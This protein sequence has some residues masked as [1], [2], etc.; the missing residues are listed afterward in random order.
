MPHLTVIDKG[1]LVE[2]SLFKTKPADKAT[3]TLL[4]LPDGGDFTPIVSGK[5]LTVEIAYVFTGKYP[6]TLFGTS[7]MLITSAVKNLDETGASAEA[8]NFLVPKVKK[9]FW[10]F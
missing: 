3:K 10:L 9:T 4:R 7:P 1:S 6:G 5:P 8:V 2:N